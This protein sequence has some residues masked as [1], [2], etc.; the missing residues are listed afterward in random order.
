M[1]PTSVVRPFAWLCA[2]AVLGVL[3]A[4]GGRQLDR[5]APAAVAGDTPV[6]LP[7]AEYLAPMSLGWR[8]VL[9][10]VIWFRTISYFGQ[11]YRSDRT[12]PWLAAMCDLVT[13]LDPRA[14]HVYRFAGVILP[15]EADQVDAGIRLLEKGVRQFPDSWL[16]RYHLGFLQFFFKNE[17]EK[18]VEQ[19]RAAVALPGAHPAI[20][21]LAAVLARQQYGPE[22]TLAFLDELQQDVDSDDVRGIVVEQMREARLA[23]DLTQL[24]AAVDAYHQRVGLLP[25]SLQNLVSEG[26]IAVVP[27]EPF[28]GH[29]VIDERGRVRS[30]SGRVPSEL[31]TSKYRRQA[32]RGESL[33]DL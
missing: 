30:S 28:D 17:P 7:K 6:Y 3:V 20:A 18:A 21:R 14:L 33:R 9:A 23:A 1:L 32:L 16:L 31:H 29:Y 25:L 10:D 12:Y 2:F 4:V 19:L 5:T 22:T 15:W 24:Q 27:Q 13:D 8:N 11:H 26:L